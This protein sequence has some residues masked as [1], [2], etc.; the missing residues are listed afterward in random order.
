M[1]S[2]SSMISLRVLLKLA[3]LPDLLYEVKAAIYK[4]SLDFLILSNSPI[5]TFEKFFSKKA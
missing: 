2:L 5:S 4:E 3:E 1:E